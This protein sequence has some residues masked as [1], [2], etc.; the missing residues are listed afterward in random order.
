LTRD[1][2]ISLILT[3]NSGSSSIKFGLYSKGRVETGLL[4]GSVVGIGLGSGMF[5]V[6][7]GD[8]KIIIENHLQPLEHSEGLKEIIEWLQVARIRRKS[9]IGRGRSKTTE[10]K[11]S[12]QLVSKPRSC[13]SNRRERYRGEV[14]L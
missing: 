8:G 12:A 6:R 9:A 10:A 3:I 4:S 13:V 11:K 5:H 14:C 2:S 1:E 7:G